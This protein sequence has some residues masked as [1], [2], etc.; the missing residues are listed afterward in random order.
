MYKKWLL[1]ATA[2]GLAAVLSACSQKGGF[3]SHT[4]SDVPQWD[5]SKVSLTAWGNKDFDG[6]GSDSLF[7]Y[8]I[9]LYNEKQ[10]CSAE[11][12]IFF[13]DKSKDDTNDLNNS[14][15]YLKTLA[16]TEKVTIKNTSINKVQYA[17]AD[18]STPHYEGD[19]D[20]HRTAVRVFSTPITNPDN[21]S[22]ALPFVVI[23]M[24]CKNKSDISD[25]NWNTVVDNFSLILKEGTA[26]VINE[27]APETAN[28]GGVG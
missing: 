28:T 5:V 22:K 21:G 18:Y 17:Y 6:E 7:P 16:T 11:G 19:F 2:I 23:D 13:E 14:I 25:S 4:L 1:T 24:S 9:K 20:N 3:D 27:E 12:R 8:Y 26:Q 10:D 15:A